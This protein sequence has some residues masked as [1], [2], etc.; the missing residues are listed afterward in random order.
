MN[1]SS[2]SIL[3]SVEVDKIVHQLTL[4]DA[5]DANSSQTDSKIQNSIVRFFNLDIEN[6]QQNILYHRYWV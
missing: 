2:S 3:K 5:C 4:P 1:F 6:N